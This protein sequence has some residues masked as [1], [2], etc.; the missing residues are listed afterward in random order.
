[1]A[2]RSLIL[3]LLLAGCTSSITLKNANIKAAESANLGAPAVF[4]LD[5]VKVPVLTD[6]RIGKIRAIADGQWSWVRTDSDL[7]L[8]AEKEWENFMRRHG[9]TMVLD[10][11]KSDYH[12]LCDIEK[13]YA[14]KFNEYLGA[15]KF[16]SHVI[17]R[18]TIQRASDGYSVYAKELRESYAV[19]IPVE[20]LENAGDEAIYNHC[21]SAVFQKC[22]EKIRLP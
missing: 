4:F 3:C 12:V 20:G 22:L 18:V 10:P 16:A 11:K 19:T 9:Q 7:S 5:K 15:H 6:K 17:M 14:E 8:W 13:I 2:W 21:L 1:M